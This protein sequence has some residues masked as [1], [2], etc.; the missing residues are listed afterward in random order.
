MSNE[1]AETAQCL[2]RNGRCGAGLGPIRS[3]HGAWPSLGSQKQK[4]EQGELE[5]SAEAVAAWLR[6]LNVRFGGRPIACVW[7]RRGA[8]C[9]HAAQVP[10]WCCPVIQNAACF[11]EPLPSGSKGDPANR[12][13]LTSCY[14][15]ATGYDG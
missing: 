11:R 14:T 10:Q 3:T 1:K 8:R 13:L 15:I 7:S 9:L 5:N 12:V 6:I 2:S 4:Q